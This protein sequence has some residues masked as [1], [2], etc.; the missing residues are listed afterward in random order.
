MK[1]IAQISL[2]KQLALLVEGFIL[3]FKGGCNSEQKY[4]APTSTLPQRFPAE[5]VIATSL[6][7][8]KPLR[9]LSSRCLVQVSKCSCVCQIGRRRALSLTHYLHKHSAS[10]DA[11]DI[12]KSMYAQGRPKQCI[13][14]LKYIEGRTSALRA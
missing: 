7:D 9:S 11:C 6:N 3:Y 13:E 2:D 12:E 10:L 5:F 4:G 8:P 14:G 1:E